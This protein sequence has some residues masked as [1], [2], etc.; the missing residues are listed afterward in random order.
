[1]RKIFA[2]RH[3]TIKDIF[4]SYIILI[5]IWSARIYIIND[6]LQL[7]LAPW[8]NAILNGSIKS[9]IWALFGIFYIK[10]YDSE[11][12]MPSNTLFETRIEWKYFFMVLMPFLAVQFGSM[13][14]KYNG[15]HIGES[16]HPSKLIGQFLIVG[17]LEELVFRGWF[18]NALASLVNDTKA[19]IIQSLLFM[20]IHFPSYID[21]GLFTF[22]RILSISVFLFA[23]GMIFGWVF[24]KSKSLWPPIIL[25]MIWDLLA[26]T[27]NG[28]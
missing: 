25:H 13:F 24:R 26:I 4:V 2:H 1:M 18:F 9:V 8:P 17:I 7:N 23:M 21:H 28:I 22:P 27:I 12:C 20:G 10:R 14:F 16:F 15:F 11:L 3:L 6:L 19:N 5:S